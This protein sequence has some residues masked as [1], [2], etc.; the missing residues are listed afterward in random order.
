MNTP[1]LLTILVALISV[2]AVGGVGYVILQ[3]PTPLLSDAGFDSSRISPNADGV[4]DLVT[5]RYTL[6]DP[7]QVSMYFEDEA[8]QRYY[9]RQNEQRNSGDHS[10]LFSGVV[11]GFHRADE[12][13]PGEIERRLLSSG[14]Y[15]WV[16]EAVS[17]DETKTA[18]GTLT[19]VDSDSQLPVMS[20]F[21]IHPETFTPNQDGIHD[22]VN[23]NIYL[24][25]TA[26]LSVYLEDA[27]GERYYLP[28][29][30]EGREPGDMGN[31]EFDYDGGV[32]QGMEPPPDEKYAVYA[33]AQD[34][35]GQR[36][37]RRGE[38]T[39][40]DG[41]LPQVEIVP[42]TTGSVVWFGALPYDDHMFT[43]AHVQGQVIDK[44][45]GIASELTTL[46][47]PQ[48]DLLVFKLTVSNYG[49]TP[50]RTA[51]P[52]PGTVYQFGQQ[53]SSLAAYEQS[54]AWRIGIKCDTSLSDFPWRWA[55]A[56]LD[57]LESVHDQETGETYY[58]L[59]PGQRAETWGAIRMTE[60]ITARNPQDCWA[61]LIH[62]DVGIS[63]F[64][65]R[66]GAREIE[67]VPPPEDR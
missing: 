45:S 53:A 56:P 65:S 14:D 2:A 21:E 23:I 64:Q 58:Y 52:F 12:N 57:E 46:T 10:F 22:R 11:A 26:A 61:G 8:G 36:I 43:D 48:N 6:S 32:D 60:L 63:A 13:I 9:F 19:L 30:E 1:K 31:H 29:R 39:I 28:E 18:T 62:E 34:D 55:I 41:G 66:V 25:K 16:M 33:V 49:S 54:G 20:A 24:E 67:I 59:Q 15:T 42:Q 51:G 17:G 38:L 35:E 37:V 44:P 5:F 47:L 4:D 3:P 7:A 50:I 40:A 27:D